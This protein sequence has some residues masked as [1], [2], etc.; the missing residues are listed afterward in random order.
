MFT[1]FLKLKVTNQIISQVLASVLIISG[2]TISAFQSNADEPPPTVINSVSP[3]KLPL[4][5]GSLE[6][7]GDGFVNPNSITVVRLGSL[8]LSATEALSITA[9]RITFNAPATATAGR[10]EIGVKV[11]DSAEVTAEILFSNYDPVVGSVSPSSGRV[12]GGNTITVE[13]EG[14]S[15][16]DG[17]P[18]TLMIGAFSVTDFRVV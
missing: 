3:E 10:T 8:Q 14:F 15:P 18:V 13:G 4:T 7:T 17:A 2:F 6:I 16:S 11:G 9:N 1:R 5:G 12:S